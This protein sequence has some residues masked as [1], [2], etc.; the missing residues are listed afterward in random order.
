MGARTRYFALR[1]LRQMAR[2]APGKYP[3]VACLS[4]DSISDSIA[5]D[6][7]YERDELDALAKH[8]FPRLPA[9]RVCLDIGGNIGNH[10]L[11]FAEHFEQVFAFEPHPRLFPLLKY[12]TELIDNVNALNF[13]LSDEAATLSASAVPGNMGMSRIGRTGGGEVF[14]FDV[15]RL[16]DVPE[17]AAL[18]G[19]DFVKLDVEGHETSVI[20][21]AREVLARH[22]PAVALE[23]LN[24]E[25]EN[26]SSAAMEA[27]RSVGYSTFYEL[28]S[29]RAFA[30]APRLISR[31]AAAVNLI[32]GRSLSNTYTLAPVEQLQTRNY[33][34]VVATVDAL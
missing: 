13:G 15:R 10:T 7:R 32:L 12:N 22:R 23:V 6:G 8:L 20:S 19:I 5:V 4:F 33:P 28:R 2:E 34:M 31:G 29:N 17:I 25:V 9:R 1:H 3:Q 16:D 14:E 21:G 18:N 30:H 27:L 26:G 11:F 24:D